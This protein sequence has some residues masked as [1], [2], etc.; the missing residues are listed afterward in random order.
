ML[1]RIDRELQIVTGEREGVTV[2]GRRG[3]GRQD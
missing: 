1:V 2:Q 3:Q